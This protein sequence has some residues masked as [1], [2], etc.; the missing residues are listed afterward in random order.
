MKFKG[1][2]LACLTAVL[3]T[4]VAQAREPGAPSSVPPGNTMGV[5]IG[6]SPPPGFYISSRTGIWDGTLKDGHG[7]DAGQTN[8]LADTAVQLMWVPG[9]KV[10]GGDYKAF[11]TIPV[12]SNDQNRSAP[13]PPPLQGKANDTALGNIEIAPVSLS[14]MVQPGIFVS[15]GLSLY[16]PT[17]KFSPTAAVNSG[18]DFWTISPSIGYSYLRDG[19]NL[20]VNAAYFA[21]TENSST[22]YRSGNEILV[23]ATALKDMG[24]FS[25]GPV[26]YW[27]KQVTGD[28]NKGTE[29]GGTVQGKSA[30]AA[31][32][33]GYVTHLG[34]AELNV[35]LTRDVYIRN[36]V[37]G[38]KLWLNVTMPLGTKG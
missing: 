3:A 10:F 33:I 32:G 15:A 9:I 23:N 25:L 13:F 1:L 37:G 8:T 28:R 34:P 7:D 31:L 2:L 26:G 5:A 36:T 11:V 22:H 24:G 20:S 35:N 21:N 14:W 38:T 30:Q 19:W 16:A 4:G 27:R 12:I 18:A 6:A 29:Y 17:G